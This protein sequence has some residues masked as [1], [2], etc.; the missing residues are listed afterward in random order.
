MIIKLSLF[1]NFNMIT[2]MK[3]VVAFDQNFLY[4]TKKGTINLP[5]SIYFAGAGKDYASY[6]IKEEI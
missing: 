1:C 5:E 3:K 6:Q 4:S 2:Y